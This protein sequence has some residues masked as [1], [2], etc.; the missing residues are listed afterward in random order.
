MITAEG[1][2]VRRAGNVVLR[3]VCVRVGDDEVLGI[4][5]PNGSGKSTLLACLH[6]AVVPQEGTVLLDGRDLAT[7]SRRRIASR[8]AVLAQ[9]RES[10]LPLSVRDTVALGRYASRSL[11]G[12]GDE[13]DQAII[14]SA[15][16]RLQITSLADRLVTELS[17]GERQ[18][19]LVARAI[20][21]QSDHLLLDEPTNHLDLRHQLALLDLIVDLARSTVVVLHDLNLAARYC[22]RVVVLHD[23]TVAADGPPSTVLVPQL[24]REVFGLTLSTI[25]W[26]GRTHLLF[27]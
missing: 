10:I 16:D 11:L 1:L 4:V 19:A 20:A 23:G 9:E 8:V 17:G 12:Y 24:A 27:D 7:M 14:D 3:D 15:M 21:Q 2:T 18:R 25:T 22:D 5:G 13:K 6:H 26:N